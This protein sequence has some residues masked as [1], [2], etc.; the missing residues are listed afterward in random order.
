M[1]GKSEAEAEQCKTA[2]ADMT[3]PI[4]I[5]PDL[6]C[7]FRAF[8]PQIRALSRELTIILPPTT[9]AERIDDAAAEA[10][11]G[12]PQR[13]AL[14]GH[15]YGGMIGLEMLRRSPDRIS[16]LALIGT[17]PLS[18]TPQSAAARE[19]LIV[20]ARAGRFD[21]VIRA[22]MTSGWLEPAPDMPKMDKRLADMAREL[23]P[24]VYIRQARA[25]QRR[26]D[27]Q[28]VLRR[29]RQP[30][31]VICGANDAYYPIKRH[32]FLAEMI[33]FAKLEIIEDAGH[34]P[35]LEQPDA[36]TALL[37]SWMRQPLVLR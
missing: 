19:L 31:L 24:E 1:W 8:L 37:R 22:E 4:V 10:L 9:Q 15:G 5:L 21:D 34:F 6:L 16:R 13:F 14:V 30:A 32:E 23:G 35:S 27:Q 36:L 12:L 17:S 3:E 2:D 20:A 11:T 18:E 25:M 7:D 33:P 28:P 26:R 29:I